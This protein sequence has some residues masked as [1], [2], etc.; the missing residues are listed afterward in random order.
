[1]LRFFRQIRKKLMDQNNI[2]SYFL[3]ASGE[4]LLVVIGILIALQVNNWN[5]DRLN[6]KAATDYEHRL[7]EDIYEEKAILGAVI[8]YQSTVRSY[9]LRAME[10]LESG[11]LTDYD[12]ASG[13]LI[14]LYQASQLQYPT[15]AISTYQEL[16]SSGQI[17][18][19]GDDSLRSAIITYYNY[20]WTNMGIIAN[21]TP[22][23]ENL[24]KV[25]PNSIQST[26]RQDCGDIYVNVRKSLK[27]VL[28]EK[29]D[30]Q[31]DQELATYTVNEIFQHESLKSDLR[32]KIGIL[33]GRLQ[34]LNN[35]SGELTDIINQMEVTE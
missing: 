19:I 7:L 17:G 33:D 26:I 24:R 25:I 28:P 35:Y 29:C 22:F 34:L 20:D 23:R 9:A 31:F 8:Q 4:I 5:Q 27:A 10:V 21:E 18:M 12:L 6:V 1:M 2:R 15:S 3:Y 14:D 30:L 16:I 13:F 32:F 11:L